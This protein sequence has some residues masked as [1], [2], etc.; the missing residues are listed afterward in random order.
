MER[1][2]QMDVADAAVVV[3]CE[4]HSLS[5][6][7]TVDRRDFSVYRQNDRRVINFIAPPKR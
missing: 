7:L 2:S 5:Q 6:V 4:L 1:Y 3:M